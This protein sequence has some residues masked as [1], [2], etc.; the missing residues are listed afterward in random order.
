MASETIFSAIIECGGINPEHA[1]TEWQ[2][3]P[4][5]V[6][7]RIFRRDSVLDPDK[8]ASMLPVY[9]RL[10]T[11]NELLA[12]LQDPVNVSE[13]AEEDRLVDQLSAENHRLIEE[14]ARLQAQVNDLLEVAW[15]QANEFQTRLGRTGG[16]A[17]ARSLT[18]ERRSEIARKAA[19]ARHS[20][21]KREEQ[22]A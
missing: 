1:S 4:G 3:L 2:E 19:N 20:R 12:F 5:W 22:I 14:N 21:A 15:R 13:H 18:A 7:T 10:S 17:R 9:W 11:E 16:N 6:R 8:C